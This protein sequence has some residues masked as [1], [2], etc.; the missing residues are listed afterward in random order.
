VNTHDGCHIELQALQVA[1]KGPVARV[2]GGSL[3]IVEV[4]L[5]DDFLLGEIRDQHACCMG[6]TL[7]VVELDDSRVIGEDVFLPHRLEDV[8][9]RPL[10]RRVQRIP[11]GLQEPRS[12]PQDFLV[13]DSQR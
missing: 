1:V 10:L 12:R 3:R 8:A 5:H 9:F 11:V 13:V 2:G 6:K 4:R 7:D